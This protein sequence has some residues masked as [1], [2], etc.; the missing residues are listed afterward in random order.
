M[1]ILFTA[2]EAFPLA[3]VGGL[4]DVTSSLAIAL[5]HLGHEPCLILPNY[6]SIKAPVQDIRGKSVAVSLRG[7]SESA[8]LKK[9]T[10]KGKIPVYLVE[11]QRYFGVEEIY[12]QG[13]LERF[14][15]FSLSIPSIISQLDFPASIPVSFLLGGSF[16]RW[17]AQKVP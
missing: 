4:A 3:K 16:S 2:S 11:N 14:L 6:G 9:T 1:R 13:E 8:T 15:F 7:H 17:L 10:L 5:L 12:A